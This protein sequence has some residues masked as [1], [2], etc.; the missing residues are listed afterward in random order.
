MAIAFDHFQLLGE[1][2]LR[3]I[4][5][6]LVPELPEATITEQKLSS[7]VLDVIRNAAVNRVR[8]GEVTTSYSSYGGMGSSI[9]DT[10]RRLR[11]DSGDSRSY[12]SQLLQVLQYV[13]PEAAAESSIGLADVYVDER[14]NLIIKDTYDFHKTKKGQD[15][16]SLV[17]KVHALFEPGGI[18][19]VSDNNA[20]EVI[21]NLGQVPSDVAGAL[22]QRNRLIPS[23]MK[24]VAADMDAEFDGGAG[25]VDYMAN[26]GK[27]AY[28]S[29]SD[30]LKLDGY[31]TEENAPIEFLSLLK[32]E[33]DTFFFNQGARGTVKVEELDLPSPEKVPEFLM[34]MEAVRFGDGSYAIGSDATDKVSY[35]IPNEFERIGEVIDNP[36]NLNTPRPVMSSG[37]VSDGR[38][39]IATKASTLLAGEPTP[40]VDTDKLSF[41]QAFARNRSAGAETF[42]WRENEYTTKIDGEM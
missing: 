36:I 28:N 7:S 21:L 42:F 39:D 23:P 12:A 31:S 15:T 9:L 30:N 4:A 34:G 33:L 25:F 6:R 3:S 10:R 32:G 11:D 20:R 2:A 19:E 38:L 29:I 16:S 8:A 17:A 40:P 5:Q 13:S 22:R 18:F 24:Y 14:N 27:A 41:S 37:Y 26:M 1:Q 35:Q